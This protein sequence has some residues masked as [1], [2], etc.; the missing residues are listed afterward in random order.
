MNAMSPKKWTPAEIRAIARQTVDG[1]KAILTA[2]GEYFRA[3]IETSQ[4]ELST[5]SDSRSQLSTVKAVHRR[6]YPIVKEATTTEDIADGPRL[7]K[8]ESRRRALERN[9]RTNFARSAYGTIRRWLRAPGHDL[10]RLDA[11]KTSKSQLLSDAPPVR[12]HQM[13]PERLKKKAAKLTGSLLEFVRDAGRTDPQYAA[14][15]VNEAMVALAKIVASNTHPTTDA[16]VAAEEQRPLR[17]GRVVFLPVDS[18]R[19]VA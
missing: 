12:P 4:A 7:T 2:R 13:T 15:V 19:R 3:L 1:K 14:H 9:R 17:V 18:S 10:R 16:K 11:A 6:F 5:R 8:E